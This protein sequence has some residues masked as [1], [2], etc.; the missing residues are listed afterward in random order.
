MSRQL[1]PST[2]TLRSSPSTSKWQRSENPA[3][4]E[5]NSISRIDFKYHL[6][7]LKREMKISNGYEY[8]DPIERLRIATAFVCADGSIRACI[9]RYSCDDVECKISSALFS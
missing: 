2:V 1:P 3:N 9:V 6:R 4:N 5:Y 7:L 8:Y